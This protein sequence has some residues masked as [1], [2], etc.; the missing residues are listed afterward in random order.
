[1]NTMTHS[2]IGTL[3][4]LLEVDHMIDY[5]QTGKVLILATCTKVPVDPYYTYYRGHYGPSFTYADKRWTKHEPKPEYYIFWGNRS[6]IDPAIN[7][8]DAMGVTHITTKTGRAVT[9]R[10]AIKTLGQ[11]IKAAN[12][13]EFRKIVKQ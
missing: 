2:K 12:E 4:V 10:S 1:M 7:D 9:Q 13:V 3:K 11:A 5:K 6:D 8:L